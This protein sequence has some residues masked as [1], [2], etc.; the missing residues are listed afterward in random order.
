MPGRELR[1]AGPWSARQVSR[2]WS[3]WCC[4]WWRAVLHLVLQLVA[5]AV[6]VFVSTW[7]PVFACTCK[8]GPGP[9]H[10]VDQAA[11]LV[12]VLPGRPGRAPGARRP[13]DQAADQVAAAP[14]ARSADRGAR[15]PHPGPRVQKTG[16]CPGCAGLGP[17]LHGQWSA[18]QF[19]CSMKTTP[20][21]KTSIW[22]K[23]FSQLKYN[24][25]HENNLLKVWLAQ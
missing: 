14:G 8:P 13:G 21:Q 3:T 15:T 16:R 19:S 17:V 22:P 18:K 12:P 6:F 10:L 9:V 25:F 7:W 2:A 1:P 4:S 11:D 23:N 24:Q 5:V 20:F